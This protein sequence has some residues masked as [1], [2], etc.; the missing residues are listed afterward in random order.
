MG[1]AAMLRNF[2]LLCVLLTVQL[3]VAKLAI[4]PS[5]TW[6]MVFAPIWLP[7]VLYV[8][9]AVVLVVLVALAMGQEAMSARS[10]TSVPEG[11]R[12]SG[13]RARPAPGKRRPAGFTAPAR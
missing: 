7:I 1:L 5:L 3:G 2:G 13:P 11:L 8:V 6:W 10:R 12:G 9:G 4:Y